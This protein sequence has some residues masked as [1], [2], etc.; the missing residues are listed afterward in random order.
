MSEEDVDHFRHILG[1]ASAIVRDADDLAQYNG[2]WLRKYNGR[3]EL[4]L[5]P[6][7]TQ[8]VSEI[9]R[10]CNEKRC[11]ALFTVSYVCRAL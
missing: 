2:D 8:Q 9:L 4:A 1:D 5:L 11:V 6:S 10:Y 3:S 7:T